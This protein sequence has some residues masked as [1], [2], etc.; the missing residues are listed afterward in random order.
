MGGTSR[1]E[2]GRSLTVRR[3][4]TAV[5]TRRQGEV[6]VG[7]TRGLT[8]KEIAAELAIGPDAV[9]RV[10]S[11]LLVKLNATS[12]TA[13]VEAAL[14]TS[15]VHVDSFRAPEGL[16][17]LDAAPIPAIVTGGPQHLIEHVNAAARRLP[18]PVVRGLWLADAFPTLG[19]I[20]DLAFTR[21]EPRRDRVVLDPG[22]CG[23]WR[24]ADVS[25]TPVRDGTDRVA[26]LVIYFVEAPESGAIRE[27]RTALLG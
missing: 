25:V 15:T 13:L 9:K 20:A 24:S 17:L 10:V 4:G 18:Q 14:R 6:L 21:A 5:L 1:A 2:G 3:Q 27:A 8:N 11:R 22:A 26:G 19:A 7:V 16:A 12:R 23:S